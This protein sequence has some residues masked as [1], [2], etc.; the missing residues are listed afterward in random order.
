[1]SLLRAGQKQHF[2]STIAVLNFGPPTIGT[3]MILTGA[4]K[5]AQELGYGFELFQAHELSPHRLEQVL[6]QSRHPG[7]PD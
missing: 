5:R 1:M 7:H 2:H 4:E 6:G 3:Q